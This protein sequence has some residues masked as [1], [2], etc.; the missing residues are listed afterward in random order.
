MLIARVY[1]EKCKHENGSFYPG[2]D[3]GSHVM[4][5]EGSAMKVSLSYALLVRENLSAFWPILAQ[6]LHRKLTSR[7][8]SLPESDDEGDVV[9]ST[10]LRKRK[11]Q[12]SSVRNS[13]SK[14]DKNQKASI[15]RIEVVFKYPHY[16]RGCS[17]ITL[18][19]QV[20]E[21]AQNEADE[22]PRQMD[23]HV[24]VYRERIQKLKAK[25]VKDGVL[26]KKQ[27]IVIEECEKHLQLEQDKTLTIKDSEI[28]ALKQQVVSLEEKDC[29]M[30][31]NIITKNKTL[32]V[33]EKEIDALKQQLESL[34]AKDNE[35]QDLKQ[36]LGYAQTTEAQLKNVLK[37]LSSQKA[38]SLEKTI[39]ADHDRSLLLTEFI[40]NMVKDLF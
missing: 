31:S 5:G 13:L 40:P 28:K 4:V 19:G 11:C 30:A 34:E 36:Q 9:S 37:L 15:M 1:Y 33:K 26:I 29:L 14:K 2:G 10:L 6:M 12:N 7:V 38:E 24:D 21:G 8:T 3:D 23:N 20:P 32:V 25:V 17:T 16:E 35:I 18:D 22:R 27:N 39:K